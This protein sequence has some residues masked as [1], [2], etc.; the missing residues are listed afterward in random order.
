[1]QPVVQALDRGEL[2]DLGLAAEQDLLGQLELGVPAFE[3]VGIVDAGELDELGDRLG[4]GEWWV[5][6]MAKWV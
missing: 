1:L 6:Q 2:G 5:T 3:V 4:A